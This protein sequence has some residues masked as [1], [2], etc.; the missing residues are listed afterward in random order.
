MV[1]KI[2]SLIFLP[3]YFVGEILKVIRLAIYLRNRK[4]INYVKSNSL[5]YTISPSLFDLLFCTFYF[6]FYSVFGF[7]LTSELNESL[8]ENITIIFVILYF[9]LNL[10]YFGIIRSKLL[11]ILYGVSATLLI[12]RYFLV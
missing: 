3:T 8:I 2:L 1:I 11:L 4:N 5:F 10:I 7:V 12:I 6:V 9:V